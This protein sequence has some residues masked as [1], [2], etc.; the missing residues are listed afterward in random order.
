MLFLTLSKGIE[1]YGED[2]EHLCIDL[3]TSSNYLH[4]DEKTMERFSKI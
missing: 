2:V 1:A 3:F 4:V